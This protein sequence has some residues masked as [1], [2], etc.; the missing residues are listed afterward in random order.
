MSVPIWWAETDAVPETDRLLRLGW[1]AERDAEFEALADGTLVPGRIARVDR[2]IC[3]VFAAD[4]IHRA[5]VPPRFA[6]PAVGDWAVFRPAV[7][8]GDDAVLRELLERRTG[9]TRQASGE[10]TIEQ[11]VAAN[12]DVVLLVNALDQRF[13]LRR[14]SDT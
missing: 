1:D 6:P 2:G 8:G 13:S 7:S 5:A 12:I 9:F 3:T 14:W 11:V 4:G 10:E